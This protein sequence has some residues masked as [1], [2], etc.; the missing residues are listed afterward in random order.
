[1]CTKSNENLCHDMIWYDK[2]FDGCNESVNIYDFGS[3]YN[4]I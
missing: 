1:M 2:Q 4:N 3:V